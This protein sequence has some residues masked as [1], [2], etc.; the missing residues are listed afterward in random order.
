MSPRRDHSWPSA[1]IQVSSAAEVL[2]DCGW[3]VPQGGQA[4]HPRVRPR[5]A[6]PGKGRGAAASARHGG[7]RHDFRRTRKPG[8]VATTRG[9]CIFDRKCREPEH[10]QSFPVFFF[11]SKSKHPRSHTTYINATLRTKERDPRGPREGPESRGKSSSDRRSPCGC[12]DS[13]PARLAS[14]RA[15]SDL[16]RSLGTL[17]PGMRLTSGHRQQR[18]DRRSLTHRALEEKLP[19]GLAKQFL[20]KTTRTRQAAGQRGATSSGCN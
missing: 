16:N 19:D 10:V 12:W 15:R 11:N 18:L 6:G 8:P 20:T 1:R 13:S 2:T 7:G 17:T 14:G 5:L 4:L 3:V 9:F